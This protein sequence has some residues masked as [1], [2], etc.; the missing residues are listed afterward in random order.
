[1]YAKENQSAQGIS[2]YGFCTREESEGKNIDKI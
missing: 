1:M 2:L